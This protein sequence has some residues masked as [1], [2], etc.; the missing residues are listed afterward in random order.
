MGPASAIQDSSFNVGCRNGYQA[1]A[2]AHDEMVDAQGRLRPHWHTFSQAL[3]TLGLGELTRRWEEAK[4]LIRENGVTYNVYGDPRGMDRP[5]QLD[6]IPLLISPTE[7]TTIEDGLIQR[8]RLL[9]LIVADLYGPQQLLKNGLLP[10]ELIFGHPGFLRPCHGMALPGKRYLHL[11]AADVGRSPDGSI[12]VLGDRTQSPSGA[13]YALEN[14]IVMSRMLPEVFRDCRVQRLALFFRTLRD[15]LRS[16]APHHRDN[17]RI[18]LLTPGPYNET[19]FEHAYLA[20]YL[21]YTLVEGGDLTV[22]DSRVFLKV[23]GG[24][25]PVDVILRRLDDDFCDPLELRSNSF[26]GVPGLVHALRAGHVAVANSLG[27]GVM[28]TPALMAFLPALCRFLLGQELTIPSVPT[29]WCGAPQALDHV[30]ANLSRMVIKP[31]VANARFQ[32]VFGDR[33]SGAQ[34]ATLAERIRARPADFVGQE[35]IS[36]STAPVLAGNRLEPRHLA[37]RTFLAATEDGSYS[38]IPGGLTRI[39]ASAD[40]LV[41]SMQQGGG[42]KDTWVLST[43]PVSTFSLLSSS[44]KPLEL[45]RGGHD[46]PSRAADNLYWLGRYA[47]RAEALV[48]LLRGIVVRLTEKS[49]LA[50]VPELPTLLRALSLQAKELPGLAVTGTEQRATPEEQTLVVCF[51]SDR[52]GSLASTLKS[53]RRVAGMVRDRISAD[54]WR[55]LSNLELGGPWAWKPRDGKVGYPID[56]ASALDSR[57]PLSDVLDLLNRTVSTLAAFGGLAMESMT[58]GQGWRFLDM[59]RRLERALKMVGLLGST[60]VTAGNQEGPLL[61]ALLEIADSSMTYRRRYLGSLQPAAVLDLLLADE[62]NPRS[63]AFQLVALADD[64][65]NLPWDAPLPGRSPEQRI[66]LSALTALRLADIDQLARAGADGQRAHLGDLLGRLEADLP[67]LSDA[68]SHHY[69]S[70]L[71]TARHLA[72]LYSGRPT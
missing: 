31:I 51:D 21:G 2:G 26:L 3:D 59:G 67:I 6:P 4:Q 41:V 30:L 36:L 17:P 45:S 65:D 25:Q 18:V 60:L 1:L 16:I 35:Q 48:R 62:T 33:L 56:H 27:S 15:T 28:E 47:D 34:Q 7:A 8:A 13:G 71:Q 58:R 44:I 23:L 70:H 63:L 12:W 20:G 22:R 11:Y 54:M 52:P 68:I 29:W 42:S 10:P 66:M 37:V 5:W 53:L 19:Y 55:V 32:P 69:L 72:S 14:R 50:E 9:E 49:G 46:L 39:S 43:G 64:V 61:E 24:L 57:R 38:V 40:T